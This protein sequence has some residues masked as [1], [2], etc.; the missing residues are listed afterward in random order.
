ML[1]MGHMVPNWRKTWAVI[2]VNGLEREKHRQITTDQRQTARR[3]R[4]LQNKLGS[5]ELQDVA[6]Y[7]GRIDTLNEMRTKDISVG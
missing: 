4:R 1:H 2:V 3:S 6:T 5:M 7:Y